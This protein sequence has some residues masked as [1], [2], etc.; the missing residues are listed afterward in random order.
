MKL[1]TSADGFGLWHGGDC[2]LSHTA[3]LP[4]ICIGLPA[5][6]GSTRA[7]EDRGAVR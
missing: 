2:L 1:R 4:C 5:T 6:A 7:F 3:A